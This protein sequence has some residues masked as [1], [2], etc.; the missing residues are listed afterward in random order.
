MAPQQARRRRARPLVE[1]VLTLPPF[2]ALAVLMTWPIAKH[3]AST[4]ASDLID[5]IVQ[6]WQF[7]WVGHAVT[8]LPPGQWFDGNTFA[9][10][11]D[12]LAFSDSLLGLWPV[13]LGVTGPSEALLRYNI[14][15]ILAPALACWATYLLARQLGAPRLAA[16]VGGLAYGFSPWRVG[17]QGHLNILLSFGI[18]LALA[19]LARGHGIGRGPGREPFRPG[20]AFSGWL[21]ATWQLS[22][23]FGLG[24]G[25]SYLLGGCVVVAAIRFWR[26]R[27]T[28]LVVPRRLLVADGAGLAVFLLAGVLLALPYQAVVAH[29]PE[30]RR[31]L[32]DVASYSPPSHGL[33]T[34]SENS[35]FYA[36]HTQV[37]RADLPT[38][39]MMLA[40]GLTALTLAIVGS[41][42]AFWTRRRR[43]VLVG[44]TVVV[45]VLALGLRGPF[46][47]WLSY[48]PLYDLAP[49]WQGVRTPGR[50]ATLAWLG[51]DVLATAG[52]ATVLTRLRGVLVRRRVGGAARRA[53]TGVLA[54]GTAVLV[55]AEGAFAAPIISP[56]L[57]TQRLADVVTG[58]AYIV[59][60]DFYQD[61]TFVFWSIDGFPRI[62]NGSSGV[63][64]TSLKDLREQTKNFPDARSVAAMR[65]RGITEL[66]AVKSRLRF[67]P[68]EDLPS[69]K[70]PAALNLTVQDT[71]AYLVYRL[72]P[73]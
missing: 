47:G 22:L 44:F 14:L 27:R 73:R 6:A 9:P 16:L 67:T 58:T 54:I 29:Y 15:Y 34:P 12:S 51:L 30:S 61:S 32:Q 53:V 69:R 57:P 43:R 26:G 72:P 7:S 25:F 64:P 4:V 18:P 24:L 50:L 33:F 52:A 56:E 3:P 28:G 63:D 45:A 35:R 39:E 10:L 49:G 19:M 13:G 23:G 5:P 70:V 42:S 38:G 17:Q 41:F 60:S 31:S 40:P 65:A 21:V 11:P 71:G 55:L 66:V 36:S 1:A 46:E 48:R 8:S 62:A 37:L 20:W 59:P 2:A 68:Y